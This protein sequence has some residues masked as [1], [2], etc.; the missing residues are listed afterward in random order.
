MR[1]QCGTIAASKIITLQRRKKIKIVKT[2]AA[3][4]FTCI[5]FEAKRYIGIIL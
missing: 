4:N 5:N 2:Y 3:F 1:K